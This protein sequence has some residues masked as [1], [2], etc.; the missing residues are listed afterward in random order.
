MPRH[1]AEPILPTHDMGVTRT[2]YENL[3]FAAGYHDSD[4]EILRREHLVV[5]LELQHDLH[6]ERNRTSCYWRVPNADLLYLE[7]AVLGLPAAGF[8]SMTSP[9]DEPWGM[10][11]FTMRDPAGNLIRIGHEPVVTADR[12]T[13]P[14]HVVGD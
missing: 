2:F 7:F 1:G 10:R 11:E 12:R 14:G 6:P 3:G 4:Y 5:H 8:P 9:R 13:G